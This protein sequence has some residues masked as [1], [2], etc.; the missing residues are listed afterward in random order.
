MNSTSNDIINNNVET[1]PETDDKSGKIT[2]MKKGNSKRVMKGEKE[3][4]KEKE[5]HDFLTD[6]KQV[7]VAYKEQG[8]SFEIPFSLASGI[9]LHFSSRNPFAFHFIFTSS[10]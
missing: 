7:L 2:T 1:N 8:G 5:N 6:L 4:E 9:N 10:I 3:K